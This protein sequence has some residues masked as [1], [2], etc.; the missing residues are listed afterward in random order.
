MLLVDL[1]KEG[2][3]IMTICNACRYC[4]GYCAVFPAMERR[5]NFA[6]GDLNYLAN[7]CHNC[8]E[9]L[10]AC[11]YAP[12]HQFA[13][14]VPKTLAAIRTESYKSYAWPAPL[15]AAFDRNALVTSLVLV[16]MLVVFLFGA[17]ALVGGTRLLTPVA[18]GDFYQIVPHTVMAGGFSAVSLVIVVALIVGF[19]RFWRD[20][21]ETPADFAHPVSLGQ[22]LRDALTLV[23]LGGGGAGCTNAEQ[24]RSTLRRWFHHATFY[25]FMLCFA[26][27]LTGTIY[28][29]AF[30]WPAPYGYT[31]LPVILGT[32]G[33]VGLVVGPAGLYWLRRR[34]DPELADPAQGGMDIAFIV[35]LILTS[36]TGLLLLAFRE[37][38]AMGILLVVHLGVVMALFLTLPYG[39]FVHGIYRAAALVK[40]ARERSRPA[41]DVGAEG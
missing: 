12:P 16:A 15:A 11:Q 3:R 17:I 9:C 23:N 29:Y 22:G 7:L 20:A 38:P 8:G 24:D 21:G 41:I 5:L 35:L 25:G 39:K 10:Y 1:M 34:R 19:V 37:T 32:M 18:T 2:E 33:G 13:V 30:G 27:T 26:A 14:N 6:S 40:F 31:S 28:H 36:L 4:E